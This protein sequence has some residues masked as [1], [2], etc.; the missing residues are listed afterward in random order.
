MTKKKKRPGTAGGT[1]EP[2]QIPVKNPVTGKFEW[3]GDL[4]SGS[5]NIA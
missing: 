3:A 2:A 4:K 1:R 5:V